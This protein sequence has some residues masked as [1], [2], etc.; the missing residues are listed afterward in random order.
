MP[1]AGPPGPSERE[2]G[3]SERISLCLSWV[4]A[5]LP[6]SYFVRLPS[7]STMI[8]YANIPRYADARAPNQLYGLARPDERQPRAARDPNDDWILPLW[9]RSIQ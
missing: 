6:S 1:K 4:T 3:L 9:V 7:A 8:L 5:H 2:L